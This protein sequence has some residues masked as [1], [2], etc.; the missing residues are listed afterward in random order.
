MRST[1][2]TKFHILIGYNL[3]AAAAAFQEFATVCIWEEELHKDTNSMI[4]TQVVI[5]AV[6]DGSITGM[7]KR[8]KRSLVNHVDKRSFRPWFFYFIFS[9][10]RKLAHTKSHFIETNV[11][12]TNFTTY[13]SQLRVPGIP[14]WTAWLVFL[15][16]CSTATCTR[17]WSFFLNENDVIV[18]S[19]YSS[20][21][22]GDA[23]KDMHP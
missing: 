20:S 1:T 17:K 4:S 7:W 6:H 23:R 15:Q 22:Q 5:S 14:I 10:Y 2:F 16:K 13:W 11:R 9:L 18:I 21:G 3:L 19:P 8:L 12:N